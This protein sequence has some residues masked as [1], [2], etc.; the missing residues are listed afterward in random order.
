MAPMPPHSLHLLAMAFMP[1]S[2]S[3]WASPARAPHMHNK[4]PPMMIVRLPS[5]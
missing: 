5:S 4:P 1:S 2:P 3:A